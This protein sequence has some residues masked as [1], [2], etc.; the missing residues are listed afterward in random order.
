MTLNNFVDGELFFP[1][2]K[3]KED[4]EL[5]LLFSGRIC[6]RKGME[7][8]FALANYIETID[9]VKL[10]IASNDSENSKMFEGLSKTQIKTGLLL[11]DM[12]DFY[13]SGDIFYFPTLY[14]G[15]SMSTLEALSCGIPVIGTNFAIPEEL[16]VYDFCSIIKQDSPSEVIETAKKLKR[17]FAN[18]RKDIFETI[19]KDF[20]KKQYTEKLMRIINDSMGEHN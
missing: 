20:G 16:K 5:I 12:N 7:Q 17:C 11:K 18:K 10:L 9:G 1:K 8:L 2:A 13:N 6:I 4:K 15:F 19:N 3:Q 14:E